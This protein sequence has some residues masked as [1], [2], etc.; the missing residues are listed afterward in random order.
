MPDRRTLDQI[1]WNLWK[2]NWKKDWA[3]EVKIHKEWIYIRN[4]EVDWW[5]IKEN[6][7]WRNLIRLAQK[8]MERI[9]EQ[10]SNKQQKKTDK[11][12]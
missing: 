10:Y 1:D 9:R 2:S 5:L 4:L 8:A 12:S 7:S 6:I 3:L 11:F